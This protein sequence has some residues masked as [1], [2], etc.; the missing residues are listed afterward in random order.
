[1]HNVQTMVPGGKQ[2]RW[3]PATQGCRESGVAETKEF[4]ATTQEVPGPVPDQGTILRKHL[5]GVASSLQLLCHAKPFTQ[6][7]LPCPACRLTCAVRGVHGLLFI[8]FPV[9]CLDLLGGALLCDWSA[10][11]SPTLLWDTTQGECV[12]RAAAC[13]GT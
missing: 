6:N 8:A 2:G 1:M 9:G 7:A 11:P 3:L 4:S 10:W 13:V 12:V 5:L